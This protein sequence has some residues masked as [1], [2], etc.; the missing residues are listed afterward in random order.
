MCLSLD[1]PVC[2]LRRCC[3]RFKRL[4]LCLLF[5]V[6][7]LWR[8][9]MGQYHKYFDFSSTSCTSGSQFQQT[10]QS[11]NYC[12][13][14]HVCFLSFFHIPVFFWWIIMYSRSLFRY[15]KADD[16]CLC[17]RCD[18]FNSFLHI[19]YVWVDNGR[20]WASEN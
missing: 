3:Y 20:L 4:G 1:L 8:Y 15:F 6:R 2:N 13:S 10:K 5:S 14:R 18:C 19:D 12:L 7:L 11:S 17:L 9:F 16:S